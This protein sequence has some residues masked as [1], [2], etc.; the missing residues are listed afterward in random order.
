MKLA[1]ESL[2]V[3]FRNHGINLPDIRASISNE[4]IIRKQN[5]KQIA[6]M[7]HLALLILLCMD[8]GALP[9]C[10][11]KDAIIGSQ[12]CSEAVAKFGL[13]VHAGKIG[14]ESKTKVIFF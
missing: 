12:I 6:T 5:P 8:Y 2:V 14:K 10:S 1:A 13:I 3:E 4:C 7:D 11:R 9:F